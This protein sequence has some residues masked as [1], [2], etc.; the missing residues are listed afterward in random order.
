ML[1]ETALFL[2]LVIDFCILFVYNSN[3]MNCG[4]LF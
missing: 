2:K 3:V 1:T 4:T